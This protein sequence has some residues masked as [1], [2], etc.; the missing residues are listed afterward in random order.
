MDN[1]FFERNIK[2][3]KTSV[4]PS[5]DIPETL[6][7]KI[8][9]LKASSGQPTLRFENILLHSI[10][11][12]E[13]E[14]RRFAEKLQVGARVCLYGFGLGYHLD[15]ILDKIGPDGYLLAIEL[16]PDILTAALTLRDQTGIFED[17]RFHLIFGSDETEVSREIS[18]EM[19]RVTRDH[20]DQ[21]EVFF[22]APSFKCIP[23][24]FPSLTNA[25]EVLLL[26]RRFPAIFG[27][28][29][30]AN[31][32][33]NREIVTSSPGINVLK[34]SEKGRPGLL[35]SA[36]PSLDLI[37][38]YLHR[39]QKEF[40][41]ACVDT[42]FPILVKNNI[43]PDHVFSLDPQIDSAG[44]FVDFPAGKTTERN[45]HFQKLSSII[46]NL[47]LTPMLIAGDFNLAPRKEDGWY[48]NTYSNFTKKSERE[49]FLRFLR[50][51]EL[52]D[53][54]VELDW[55]PT[56]ERDINGKSSRFR[57]DLFLLKEDLL[58]LSKMRY[59]HKFRTQKG[60]SDH[61]ALLVELEL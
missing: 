31:Y 28:L 33:L 57:C 25:L 19:E 59:D 48:G 5:Q 45:E 23:S 14:A 30:K 51:Y 17:R 36:G 60:L 26:E 3:L 44:H 35:V 8:S 29:E 1:H 6:S 32:S 22:H 47:N 13:K 55:A 46:D 2:S 10:Y 34:N 52:Y 40:L 7:E 39:M 37:L 58:E 49:N 11:D 43:Q 61:S 16:N 53:L 38:P 42:A 9:V 56:L 15:P 20:A 50:K 24:T 27:N 41:I 54:G 12:P 21:L 18:H 4:S